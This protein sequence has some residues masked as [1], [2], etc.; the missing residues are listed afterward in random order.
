MLP[1]SAFPTRLA[2]K[3]VA[4]FNST[5]ARVLPRFLDACSTIA[6][7][8]IEFGGFCA[9]DGR[10]SRGSTVASGV[11][12]DFHRLVQLLDFK[13]LFQNGHGTDLQ[14]SVQHLAVGVAGDHD[15]F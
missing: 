9:P 4:G 7:D 13:R 14:N 6:V 15:H 3:K 5:L 11:T 10:S 1:D 2:R 8:A 12:K